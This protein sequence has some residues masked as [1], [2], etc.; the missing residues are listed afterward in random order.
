MKSAAKFSADEKMI[1][2]ILTFVNFSHV[3]DFVIMMPLAPRM[4]RIFEISSTQFG[5]LLSSYTFSAGAM[6]FLSAFFLD[7]F[8]RRKAL[9]FF[10]SG[11]GIATLLCAISPDYPTLLMARTTTGAFGGVL[12]SICLAII[13]DKIS[14]DRR[15]TAIGMLML[16]FSLASVLEI[17][18]FI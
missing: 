4:I 18:F 3:M 1:I 12:N 14:L 2:A 11:F 6:G 5:F 7:R 16:G 17:D 10:F 13:A 8:D 9:L 15:A